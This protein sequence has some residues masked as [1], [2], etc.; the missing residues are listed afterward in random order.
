MKDIQY[1]MHY[2]DM[3]P[4]MATVKKWRGKICLSFLF[5]VSLYQGVSFLF[6]F[7]QKF[8]FANW[9]DHDQMADVGNVVS[10]IIASDPVLHCF[11]LFS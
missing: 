2:K 4:I 8:V 5:R 10:Q 3:I 1:K 11:C 7:R 9:F 6:C